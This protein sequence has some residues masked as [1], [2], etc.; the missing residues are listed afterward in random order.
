MALFLPPLA[1]RQRRRAALDFARERERGAAHLGERPAP[2]DAHVDVHAA[3]ARRLRP[4]DQ[5]EVVERRAAPR[6][7]PRA[8]ASRRR[9]APDRDRRAARR[10]DRDRRRAPGADAA[11]GRPGWPSTRA[12]PRRA[13]RLP[14]RCGR[15]GNCSATTSIQ[16]GRDC[17]RALLVEELAADAVGIAD[18][19]V[20][21]AAGRPQRAVGD[22]EVV[23][24]EV[25]LRVARRPGR[26]PCSGW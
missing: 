9:R 6:A 23:A 13:A 16:S 19:D 21:P 11:R 4:A 24:H 3:R 1:R 18:E 20:R 17:R 14:R 7:R 10:D 8:P 5:A 22:G 15:T 2:L 25:E 26:A 12:P